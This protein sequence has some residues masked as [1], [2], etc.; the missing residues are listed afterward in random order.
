MIEE[1]LLFDDDDVV[2]DAAEAETEEAKIEEMRALISE[3][4]AQG[5]K[6]LGRQSIGNNYSVGR[7]YLPENI[8]FMV[9][10]SDESWDLINDFMVNE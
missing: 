8:L 6:K 10:H 9:V 4:E 5:T 7:F 2:E 3:R 1:E